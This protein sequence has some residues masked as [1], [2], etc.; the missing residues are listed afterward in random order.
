MEESVTLERFE[1]I[2]RHFILQ[3]T[4]GSLDEISKS[5]I[6]IAGVPAI[7]V[8]LVCKIGDFSVKVGSAA[9]FSCLM[10]T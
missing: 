2:V 10:G 4:G 6:K 9:T 1:E 3:A 7:Q 8:I 5:Q